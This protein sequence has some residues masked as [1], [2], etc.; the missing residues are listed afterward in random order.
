VG[1]A[2]TFQRVLQAITRTERQRRR[3]RQIELTRGYLPYIVGRKSFE[4]ARSTELIRKHTECGEA[5]RIQDTL[6]LD[7][8]PIARGYYEKILADTLRTGW[9]GLVDFE[10]LR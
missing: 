5:P 9:G 7:G 4:N 3:L 1:L 6:G 2:Y 8:R 10:R